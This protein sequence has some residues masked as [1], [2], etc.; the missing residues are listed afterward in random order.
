M[1]TILKKYI[2]TTKTFDSQ[3]AENFTKFDKFGRKV[4]LIID[5]EVKNY[6]ENHE[7]I[8]AT[9][10][11]NEWL[12]KGIIKWKAFLRSTWFMLNTV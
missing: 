6:I 11:L 1:G 3:N 12:D 4:T 10:D 5:E 8:K 9:W 7:E 2:F